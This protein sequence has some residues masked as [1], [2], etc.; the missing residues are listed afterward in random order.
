MIRIAK[1]FVFALDSQYVLYTYHFLCISMKRQFWILAFG[2]FLSEIGTGFTLFYA[3][4]FFVNQVGLSAT[5]VG[6]ALGFGSISGIVGRILGGSLADSGKWGRRRT[7]LLSA[8][9]SA[10]GSI[11]LAATSNFVILIVGNLVYSFGAGL[12]WPATEAAVAD[13]TTSANRS[14][15][16]AATRLAD[17][18]GLGMG[19]LLAGVLVATTKNYRSL[20]IID[21]IS[22]AVFFVVIWIAIQETSQ[23]KTQKN[24]E[25]GNIK[26]WRNA[27]RDRTL[28]I[29]IIVNI[30]FTTYISQLH[31]TLPLYL[32]N[33]V[34]TGS[35]QLG[36][37]ETTISSLFA[38]HLV[39]SILMQLPIAKLLKRLSHPQA[40]TVSAVIWGISF[41]LIW[42]TAISTSVQVYMIA[43]VM[44]VFA[45][46]VVSYTPS[47]ASLVVDLAPKSQRGVYLSINS[48]CWSIGYFIGPPLGGWALD[49]QR[50]ITANLW[51]GLAISV[52][53]AILIL[54]YLGSILK[55]E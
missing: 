4:I 9:I 51:L 12:Y 55:I 13:L 33:F 26:A 41:S 19:I 47:A 27:L 3:P 22:F 14:E 46:A 30:L 18:L 44:A 32:K 31:S 23:Q 29:Y 6:F 37:P 28:R 43:V 42:L 40:L 20:F 5:S 21:A 2:R 17:N 36:F 8:A 24:F 45:L 39:V 38:W 15:A 34:S 54:Q 7:L 48:L 1:I 35:P 25:G 52:V 11:V 53:V 10:I 16:F 49:Q 50:Y